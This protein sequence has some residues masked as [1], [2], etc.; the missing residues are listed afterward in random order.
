MRA[1]PALRGAKTVSLPE[2]GFSRLLRK[3]CGR[4]VLGIEVEHDRAP[5]KRLEGYVVAG[6]R[7]QRERGG[8]Q[9]LGDHLKRCYPGL[10]GPR[11]A[12]SSFSW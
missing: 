6:V 8:G 2:A 12:R 3:G 10:V 1:A 7:R 9:S 4:I 5:P 11:D